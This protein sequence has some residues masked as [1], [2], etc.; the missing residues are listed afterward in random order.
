MSRT[1]LRPLDR[2]QAGG[3]RR[4]GGLQRLRQVLQEVETVGDLRR[5]G[6]AAP[7]AVGVGAGAVAR[8]DRDPGV[9]PQPAGEGL[10]L[11]VGQQRHR[12]PPLQVDQHGAV[13]VAL[14]QRPVVDPEDSRGDLGWQ[15][16]GPDQPQQGVARGR[17]EQSAA[18][19]SAGG[20]AQREADRRLPRGEARRPASPGRG[21]AGQALGEDAPLA[22]GVVAEQAA[23][24]QP[25]QDGVVA[26][27]QVGQGPLVAA[28][29]ATGASA[30]QRAAC[31]ARTGSEGQGDG[32]SGGLDR[33]GVE[34]DRSRVRRQAGE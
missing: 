27:R 10:G 2:A 26:P 21:G 14:A 4:E 11:A 22:A 31:R 34:P 25:D 18:E 5:L 19:P 7:G 23:R 20:T 13:A 6:R 17:H 1:T 29:D 16:G 32:G 28:V 15:R 8:H 33:P 30:A 3:V 24:P 9:V 12:P